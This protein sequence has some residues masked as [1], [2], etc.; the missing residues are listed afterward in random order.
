[1]DRR[2][3]TV[4][5]E[6]TNK[7]VRNTTKKWAQKLIAKYSRKTV[8]FAPILYTDDG[9]DRLIDDIKYHVERTPPSTSE[10]VYLRTFEVTL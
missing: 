10:R 7:E 3:N 4:A 9:M 6:L 8:S 5:K 2:N 1:M